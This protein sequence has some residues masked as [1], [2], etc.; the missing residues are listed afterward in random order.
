MIPLSFAQ[1]RL[2]F[3]DRFKGLGA[4]YNVPVV[5]RLTGLAGQGHLDAGLLRTALGDVVARHEVLRTVFRE[6]DG[7]PEQVVLPAVE[8][9]P[10]LDPVALEPAQLPGRIAAE[11]EYAFDIELELPI[12]ARLFTLAP[13]E[14]VLLLL[15]HH[16]AC[17]GWSLGPL[18]RDLSQAYAARAAGHA[19]EWDELPVQYADYAVWQREFLGEPTDP[20]SVLSVQSAFWREALAGLPEEIALPVDR[21]RPKVPGGR[22][23]V[24]GFTLPP[25]LHERLSEVA[26]ESRVTLFML[27]QAALAVL[28]SRLGAGQDVPLGSVVAGRE[29][30]ALDDL[31][32]FFVNTLVFRVDVSGDPL[33]RELLERVRAASL[34]VFAH[35]DVPFERLVEEL[36]PG[37]AAGR[38]PLFQT[39]LVFEDAA[40]GEGCLNLPGFETRIE[41]VESRFAKFDLALTMTDR[42]GPDREPLGMGGEWCFA[43]DLFD[44]ATVEGFAERFVRL[45]EAFAADPDVRISRPRILS[46]AERGLSVGGAGRPAGRAAVES[47]LPELF[48]AQ[49]AASPDATAAVCGGSQLSY[50]ELDARANRLARLLMRYG[51]GPERLVAV[52]LPRGLDLVTALLAVT[53]TGAGYLPLDTDYPAG[54]VAFMLDDAAP[55]CLLTDRASA[56]SL[57]GDESSGRQ[58]GHRPTIRLVLDDPVLEKELTALDSGPLRP[59]ERTEPPLPGN[60]AYVIYTSGST[61]RPKG[62]V[63]TH[64]NVVRLFSATAEQFDFGVQDVWTLFHSCAFDF[65]VWELWGALLHGGRLVVVPFEV[66]RSPREFLRLLSDERVTVLN[67]TPSAFYQLLEAD[68][69]SQAAL[70]DLRFV[71]FGGEQLDP[72]RLAEWY[73]RRP[74]G[75]PLLVNMYGITETTVHVTRLALDAEQAAAAALRGSPIGTALAD[76]AG[77]VLD[78][79]LEPVPPGVAGDLYVAGP[80]LARGYLGRFGLTAERF[81]ADPFAGDGGRM[82]RTGDVVRRDARGRLLYLGRSDEQVKIRGFRIELG[83]VESALA[84]VAGVAGCAVVVREDRPGDR[85][86]VAYVVPAPGTSPDAGAMRSALA[87][88]LPEYMVPAAFVVMPLLPL[89]TNGKLD[90][91]ALPAPEYQATTKGREPRTELERRLCE[92]F[93]EVLG[94]EGVSIDDGFFQ[95]GG[96]SLLVT[97]LVSRARRVLGAELAVRDVFEASTV[98]G[99]AERLESGAEAEPA[100]RTQAAFTPHEPRSSITLSYAQRRLWFISQLEGPSTVYNIPVILELLGDLDANALEAAVADLVGRH[101][102]LRSLITVSEDGEPAQTVLPVAEARIELHRLEVTPSE[103]DTRLAEVLART[104]D[105]GQEIPVRSTLLSH[106]RDRHTFV[107]LLHHIVADGESMG[108][109]LRDLSLAYNARAAGRFPVW[110]ALPVQYTD[111]ALWQE[112]LLGDPQD[113]DSLSRRQLDYWCAALADLPEELALPFDR[114]RPDVASYRGAVVGFEL[115]APLHAALVG[116][117]RDAGATLFMVLQAGVAL[118]LRK[119]GAGTDIPLGAPVAGRTDEALDDLVGCFVNTLVFRTDV[120]GRPTVRELL[121]RVRE[122]DLSAYAHQ[123]LPFEQLVEE[124][125]PERTRARNALF[126]TMI[127]MHAAEETAPPDLSGLVARVLPTPTLTA[128]FDVSWGFTET[129]EDGRPSGIKGTLTYAEELFDAVTARRFSRWLPRVLTAMTAL[130]DAPVSTIGLPGPD[131]LATLAELGTGPASPTVLADAERCPVGLIRARALAAPDR[132]AVE[133]ETGGTDY[134]TLAG[135]ASAFSRRIV[136]AGAKPGDTVAVVAERGATAIGAFLGIAGAR[137]VYVPLDPRSPEARTA[138]RLNDAG[139]VCVITDA[140]HAGAAGRLAARTERQIPVLVADGS[141]DAPDRL[142]PV[143]GGPDDLAY[144]IYTSGSTGRPKGAMVHRR[145][146]ANSLASQTAALGL[147]ATDKVA[148]T[149]PLTFDISVWQMLAPLVAGAS[150]RAYDEDTVREPAR[151]FGRAGEDGVTLLQIVPS[152][153]DAALNDWDAG[154]RTPER[155]PLRRLFVTGEALPVETA[156]RWCERYPG[157]PMVNGYGPTECSDDVAHSLIGP[158]T[159]PH[160]GRMPIGRADRGTVHYVLDEDLRPVPFGLRGELYIGG[161]CVGYGYLGDAVRTAGVFVPDPFSPLPGARMYR[162]G[163]WVRYRP[164]EQLEFLGRSDEQVKVRG[165]RIELG[166]VESALAG[167]AGVAGCAVVVRED[168]PGDRRLVAYAVAAPGVPLEAAGLGA[169]LGRVLPEYMV[170]SAFVVVPALPL[171][172]NGKLDRA[173]L[174]EPE[175]RTAA[176]RGPRTAVEEIL[177]GLFEEVLAV[178]GISIDDGFFQL[179]G[180]SLLVMRLVSRVRRVLGVEVSVRDV[181]DHPSVAGLAGRVGDASRTGIGAGGAAGA[182]AGVALVARERPEAVELSFAQRRLWFLDRMNGPSA[183]YNVPVVLRVSGELDVQALQGAVTDVVGRHEALRTVLREVDGRPAQVVTPA[184]QVVVPFACEPVS[185]DLLVD[186]VRAVSA[187]VFDLEREIPVRVRVFAVADREHVVVLLLHHIACD[188]WSTGPLLRDLSQA[189][190]ARLSGRSPRWAPLPVQYA[191]YAVWQ[192]ESLGEADDEDSVLSRQLAFWRDALAGLPQRLALPYDRPGAV[193]DGESVRGEDVP[194]EVGADVHRALAGLA[195][196][197]GVT[198]FMVVQAVVAVVL[199]SAGAGDD[200]P[201]GTPVAGRGDEALDDLVGLFVNTLVLRVDLSGDP[202]FRELLDRVRATDLAAY[203]HQ[204]VPFDRLVEALNPVRSPGVNPLFQ[205]SFTFGTGGASAEAGLPGL[206][207]VAEEYDFDA[208]SKFDLG[209]SLQ[210]RFDGSGA[211]AG[212]AGSVWYDAGLFDPSTVRRIADTLTAVLTAVAEDPGLRLNQLMSVSE[213]APAAAAGRLA[214]VPPQT[215]AQQAILE[216]WADLLGRRDFGIREDFFELGGTLPVA[217]LVLGRLERRFRTKIPLQVL[218]TAR[219]VEQFAAQVHALLLRAAGERFASA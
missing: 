166:E 132:L 80:G 83:E 200:V 34:D 65:S 106:G 119:L 144:V 22:A 109:L 53:K 142:A 189:Y 191:D 123:D 51:A 7:E 179:G 76:L 183:V 168:R 139:C 49:A 39:M 133:D 15:I 163:D 107:L 115:P 209:F 95:V 20:E 134:A 84:G 112:E 126:Q 71:C 100:L 104:F 8:A 33:F 178:E 105:L 190:E 97:R 57:P 116:L 145:G 172:A 211:P 217:H 196:G 121:A 171:T 52:C 201:L 214:P 50:G 187:S 73:E 195:R 120:S 91:A 19:P 193:G 70:P 174:P 14:H 88:A 198:L 96:H 44:R 17:D 87:S 199:R 21:V 180:H 147:S 140:R 31:V 4:A 182:G 10:V 103:L 92:L 143:A 27:F 159:E 194:V 29:D 184:D 26:R 158:H 30:E 150:V 207:V 98:A 161:L 43:E 58:N 175:F 46:E 13:T 185:S 204:D 124:L 23:G 177:C 54:R 125:N 197:A 149:A 38:H 156:R 61:G 170:P 128:Q 155:M 37:R 6:V 66:S 165:F 127:T 186:R 64:A 24:V 99:L 152:L 35:R 11:T 203:A 137:C 114:P 129:H 36:N 81:V 130:P 60:P 148:L 216:V 215:P 79:N 82:Y 75:G 12:R 101:E 173:A 205:T 68:R 122:A 154:G 138:D 28:L 162:T 74:G 176:G 55:I 16:I 181:F 2:W 219:T 67:Q 102:V 69:E 62:V 110:E 218:L 86:L 146:L 25:Q 78:A 157:I 208:A 18:L 167:L 136:A 1:R 40:T 48:E 213:L 47:T 111:Y 45:L 169:A 192:R 63:V 108:P 164:D 188:G 141:V 41:P 77:Y 56:S 42:R 3:L 90:R 202:S 72:R 59:A 212:L 85:R 9:V 206:E 153:L 151:L 93:E 32:G 89:T 94:V 118:L 117:A 5:A 160:A 135:L 210:E 131:E 113:P